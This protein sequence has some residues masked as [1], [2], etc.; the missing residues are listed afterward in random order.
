[1]RNTITRTFVKNVCTCV[2]Y[3]NGKMSEQLVTIPA[4]FNTDEKAEKYIRKNVQLDGKLASVDK[5]KKSEQL[6]GMDES[7][8]MQLA[9]V[10]DARSKD[11]RDCITKNVTAL[12]GT[13]V[14]MDKERKLHEQL[15]RVNGKRNL[16]K[17][18]RE[19]APN[20]CKGITIENVHEQSALYVMDENTFIEN[21]KPMSDHQH[22]IING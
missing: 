6:R 22:Y 16:D 18:A 3:A 1:M 5:I 4:D 8:F 12:F 11:T 7:V 10:V 14:Y 9:K 19:L 17:Q 15:V 20:D 13:L 21:S 2:I